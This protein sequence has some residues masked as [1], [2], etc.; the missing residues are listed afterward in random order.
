L[1]E[2]PLHLTSPETCGPKINTKYAEKIDGFFVGDLMGA[3]RETL[4]DEK[5]DVPKTI[6]IGLLF[7]VETSFEGVQLR[8]SRRMNARS[9]SAN[10]ETRVC[11]ALSA[12]TII[13]S[14]GASL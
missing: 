9:S 12:L 14:T 5:V 2:I 13:P 3:V 8:I 4:V 7:K 6:E 10:G 1:K 11:L